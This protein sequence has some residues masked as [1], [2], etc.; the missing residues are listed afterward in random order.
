[1]YKSVDCDGD[2]INDHACSTTVNDNHWL[3]LSTEG[4]PSGNLAWGTS[5]RAISKCPEAWTK[6][7]FILAYSKGKSAV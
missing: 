1:M 3:V 6:G 5:G 2:G 4:C 7:K